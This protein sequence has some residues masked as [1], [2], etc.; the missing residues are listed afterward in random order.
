MT[1]MDP[2]EVASVSRQVVPGVLL[3]P[4]SA[5]N[6][7]MTQ[8]KYSVKSGITRPQQKRKKKKE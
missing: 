2:S 7:G 8:V 4:D 5:R 6:Q 1:F 3:M